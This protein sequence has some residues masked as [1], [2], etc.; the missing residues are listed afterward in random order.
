M[1]A[2]HASCP[3]PFPPPECR[4]ESDPAVLAVWSGRSRVA[5][6]CQNRS[7]RT[8]R[9]T[10]A[11]KSTR[12]EAVFRHRGRVFLADRC[13]GIGASP[14]RCSAPGAP[15]SVAHPRGLPSQWCRGLR[16]GHV[17]STAVVLRGVRGRS[18][19]LQGC[20]L[21]T[22][23]FASVSGLDSRAGVVLEP[24][25]SEAETWSSVSLR[26]GARWRAV[27]SRWA[28]PA[29]RRSPA[30]GQCLGRPLPFLSGRFCFISLCG[31]NG[32]K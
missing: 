20:G 16:I 8:T 12:P 7:L 27:P 14:Q 29:G 23:P 5:H 24:V 6:S 28:C 17:P 1:L 13:P 9:K 19:G 11:T 31:K 22:A 15:T 2:H 4:E 3:C 25:V 18:L 10:T 26:G 30:S 21:S 32:I